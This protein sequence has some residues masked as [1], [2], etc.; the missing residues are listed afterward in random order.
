MANHGHKHTYFP[1]KSTF[2]NTL[3]N[4]KFMLTFTRNLWITSL[5]QPV[6]DSDLDDN[7]RS[8]ST[9]KKLIHYV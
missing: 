6:N 1:E 8:E 5:N 4:S 7:E 2:K 9:K 3:I